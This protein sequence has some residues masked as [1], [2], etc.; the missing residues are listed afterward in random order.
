LLKK[1][2]LHS[3]EQNAFKEG[4]KKTLDKFDI[5]S[6]LETIMTNIKKRVI[7]MVLRFYLKEITKGC[8]KEIKRKTN[9]KH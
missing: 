6:K 1:E 5:I 9:Y 8:N 4:Q 7:T 2:D 3:K